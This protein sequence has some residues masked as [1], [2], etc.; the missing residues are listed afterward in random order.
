M[1]PWSSKHLLSRKQT[2]AGP[3][4]PWRGETEI[5]F[6]LRSDSDDAATAKPRSVIDWRLYKLDM[7]AF[8][9]FLR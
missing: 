3:E 1:V 2:Q 4:Q 5:I 8:C 7:S 9:E 6:Q